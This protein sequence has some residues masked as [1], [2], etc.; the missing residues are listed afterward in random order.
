MTVDP[1]ARRSQPVVIGHRGSP[2]RETENTIASFDA[3]IAAGAEMVEFDVRCS[4]DGVLFVYH[5]MTLR[6]G[7]SLRRVPI[8]TQT[9]AEICASLARSPR[10]RRRGRIQG[11][12]VPPRLEDVVAHLAGRVG[13]NVEIKASGYEAAILEVLNRHV[14]AADY[15]ITS[16]REPIVAAVKRLSP[17]TRVGLIFGSRGRGQTFGLTPFRCAE[18]S[19]AD[20]I[21][22]QHLRAGSSLLARA[23]RRGLPVFLYT[24]DRERRMGHFL[25]DPRVAGV[26]TD[27]PD[28]AVRLRSQPPKT[29]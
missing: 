6:S 29:L 28:V 4:S 1:L 22:V 17:Q 25:H 26:I 21:V 27:T 18:R 15:V 2:R 12:V 3:A 19:G 9:F 7:S 20:F 13:M 24:V 11:A 8:R 16:F 10:I 23:H 5:G 14:T